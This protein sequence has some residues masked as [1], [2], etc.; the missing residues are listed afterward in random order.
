MEKFLGYKRPDG[1][2]GVRNHV[3]IL[4]S[5][6]C[7]NEVCNAIAQKV[8][9]TISIP[10][11]HGCAQLTFDAEQTARTL[12]GVG[13]NP[14]VAAVLVIG[15]GCEVVNSSMVASKIAASGK[16]VKNLVIQEVGG[17]PKTIKEG[18]KIA[19]EMVFY[20]SRL[21]REKSKPDSLILGVECGGS[22]ACS[23]LSANPALGVTSDLLVKEGGTIILSETTESIGAEH[24]LAKRAV[25][26]KVRDKI[27]E[28]VR[29]T[30]M[31]ALNLGLDI[32]KANPAPGNYEGGITTLEEK[33]LGCVMK[34]G[35][36][37]VMEVLEYSESPTQKGLVLMDTPGHDA[38]SMTGLIAGGTQMIAFTTGRGNPLGSPIAPVI[39]IASNSYL[40]SKMKDNMD[41]NAGEIV[42]GN[43]T[44]QQIGEKIFREV[45]RVADGKLT[46]SEIWG[47]REF[48]INRIGPSF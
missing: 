21:K 44:V 5:V 45:F 36:S 1:K 42:T 14:N 34:G 18:I 22:D 13:K 4:P 9:G 41:I 37:K 30:E 10:H 23:G 12:I 26:K 47:H 43:K 29:R 32:G 46:K 38:E 35:T 2:V 39:K 3:V 19:K 16:P 25:N 28:I 40:Y 20:A 8:K 33:S 7:S 17:S 31:R 11:Q 15:L 48:A 24:I 6:A 27:L